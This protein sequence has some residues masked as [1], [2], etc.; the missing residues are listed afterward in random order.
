[1]V[2]VHVDMSDVSIISGNYRLEIEI[3]K[4]A[5]SLQVDRCRCTPILSYIPN[6]E[7]I[8]SSVVRYVIVIASQFINNYPHCHR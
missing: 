8:K 4:H 6:N 2:H 5:V 7:S 1:M 3:E